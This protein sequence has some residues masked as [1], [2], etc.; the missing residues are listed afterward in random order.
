MAGFWLAR[1]FFNDG[2]EEELAGLEE[3][4]AGSGLEE[5]LAGFEEELAGSK[6]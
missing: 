3:L 4:L 5:E 2:L 6:N 1:K